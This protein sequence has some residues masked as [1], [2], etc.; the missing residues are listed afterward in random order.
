M[1]RNHLFLFIGLLAI[2]SFCYAQSATYENVLASLQKNMPEINTEKKTFVQEIYESAANTVTFKSKVTD[3]KGKS[4]ETE[5][6]FNFSDID[7]HSVR[8][9]TKGDVISIQLIVNGN[10][11]LI[12]VNEEN[13][14]I[15]YTSKFEILAKD[16]NN[17]RILSDFI[18]EIIPF[19][20]TISEKTLGLTGY[21]DRLNYLVDHIKNVSLIKKAYNQTFSIDT[22]VAGNVKLEIT[23]SA[24][25]KV[26]TEVYSFNIATLNANSI[27]FKIKMDEILISLGTRR[28]L[29]TIKVAEDGV[30]KNYVNSIEI[31]ASSIENGKN[32]V[33]VLKELI[34]LGE[35]E[36]KKNI[37]SINSV[38]EGLVFVNSLIEKIVHK[39][40]SVFQKMSTDCVTS[41]EKK[42]ETLK[43]STLSN[44][45]FSFLDLVSQNVDFKI[46]GTEIKVLLDLGHKYVQV[47]EDGQVKNYISEVEIETNSVEHAIIMTDVLKQVIDKCKEAKKDIVLPSA[48]AGIEM[49]VKEI[50]SLRIDAIQYDQELTFSKNSVG[51]FLLKLKQIETSPKKSK[52]SIYE[53]NLSDIDQ[54]SVEI[55]ISGNKVFIEFSTKFME[56]IIKTYQDGVSKNYTN[57]LTVLCT[58]V[59]NARRMKEILIA[60]TKEN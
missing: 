47:K 33:A 50:Q 7:I 30:Q 29:K 39:D 52:E 55:K 21:T 35:I 60:L 37:P 27:S 6:S 13:K 16:I 57:S 12:K 25:S 53:F 4:E 2:N 5:L 56:K 42:Q 20:V 44:Y 38:D 32:L 8:P 23:K 10:Q 28:N 51:G 19:S 31:I 22:E 34:P 9:I 26:N 17:A 1:K 46:S 24:G 59:E 48:K 14:K 18:K 36:F 41:F 43:K 54:R 45:T 15:F 49:I 40:E 3:V 11:K 58:D